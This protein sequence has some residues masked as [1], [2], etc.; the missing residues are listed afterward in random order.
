MI[1]PS[2]VVRIVMPIFK[3]GCFFFGLQDSKN[4]AAKKNKQK[5]NPLHIIFVSEVHDTLVV[6]ATLDFKCLIH[7]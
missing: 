7:C 6:L 2:S 5:L 3:V 1:I 4:G